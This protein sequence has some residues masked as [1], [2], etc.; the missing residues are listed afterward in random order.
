MYLL[1][2]RPLNDDCK[3]EVAV[4]VLSTDAS[5]KDETY[6]FTN[7]KTGRYFYWTRNPRV[8][9]GDWFL[10]AKEIMLLGFH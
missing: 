4:Y 1:D 10:E 7:V 9:N 3:N 8:S 2:E 6:E 5:S